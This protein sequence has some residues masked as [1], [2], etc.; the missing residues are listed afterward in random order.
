MLGSQPVIDRHNIHAGYTRQVAAQIVMRFQRAYAPATA[1]KIDHDRRCLRGAGTV[2]AQLERLA[3]ATGN[4]DLAHLMHGQ[5]GR[6]KGHVVHELADFGHRVA[7]KSMGG[8]S[9]NCSSTA[10]ISGCICIGTP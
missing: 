7:T 6:R 3:I 8:A 1:V 5:V 4:V 10:A 2:Q 9:L